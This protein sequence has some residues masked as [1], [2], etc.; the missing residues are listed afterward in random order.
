[1]SNLLP[2]YQ[3]M[4]SCEHKH[5][6][7]RGNSGMERII[8]MW[9][10]DNIKRW[11]NVTDWVQNYTF[12]I[13]G[14][15]LNDRE[16]ARRI[17]QEFTG[18]YMTFARDE[19]SDDFWE[20]YLVI[21]IN[22]AILRAENRLQAIDKHKSIKEA[23]DFEPE[24]TAYQARVKKFYDNAMDA[25]IAAVGKTVENYLADFNP[26][27]YGPDDV[28]IDE[29]VLATQAKIGEARTGAIGTTQTA[30]V[31]NKV[32]LGYYIANSVVKYQIIT[33]DPCPACAELSLQTY[34][35]EQAQEFQ[36]SIDALERT[37]GY[38]QY[39]ARRFYDDNPYLGMLPVHVNCVCY[40]DIAGVL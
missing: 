30:G 11:K 40:W 31:Y 29:A 7:M 38:A 6:T 15:V 9:Q 17:A 36:A 32:L 18:E 22:T 23:K 34:T 10:K 37:T 26:E 19:F 16:E 20:R 25:N 28:S 21:S 14:K 27:Q 35:A 8:S 4:P 3:T 5:N 1:M 24:H 2:F 13:D 12:R 39:S 33:N